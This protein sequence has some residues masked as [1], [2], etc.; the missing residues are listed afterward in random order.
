MKKNIYLQITKL[1]RVLIFFVF[2][3]LIPLFFFY[4]KE[5]KINWILFSIIIFISLFFAVINCKIE[6]S[7]TELKYSLFPLV[8]NRTT[9]WDDVKTVELIKL[10]A[11][12]DFLGWGLR[13]S[14]KYGWGYILEGDYGLF[15]TTKSEKKVTFSIKNIDELSS[16]LEKNQINYIKNFS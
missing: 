15:I 10:N 12:S 11:F 7:A 6:I 4:F 2:L 3:T 13:Y 1:P 14:M 5:N 9:K 8:F 16:F